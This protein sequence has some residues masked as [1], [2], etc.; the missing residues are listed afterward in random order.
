MFLGSFGPSSLAGSSWKACHHCWGI[1]VLKRLLFLS[2][3]NCIVYVLYLHILS[4]AR[5]LHY[6]VLKLSAV[7]RPLCLAETLT[8]EA[9]P[10]G[11][12]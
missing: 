1:E 3:G 2:W 10:S 9:V 11:P 12:I 5:S 8:D 4:S 7:S 6:T